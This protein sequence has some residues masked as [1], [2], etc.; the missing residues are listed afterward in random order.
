VGVERP[1]VAWLG[2]VDGEVGLVGGKAASLD[3][4]A[5]LGFRI[6][7]GFCLTTRA[8][9]AQL[10]A[11]PAAAAALAELPDGGARD[12]LTSLFEVTPLQPA[13]QGA[14]DAAVERLSAE[15]AEIGI[16]TPTFAVRS[17]GIGEDG[18]A[19]SYAGLHETE[20]GVAPDGV[21]G[22]VRRCWA[23]MWSAPAIAYRVRRGLALDGG[24]MAVVVQ[25]LVPADA[26]AVV[27]TRHP[28]TGRSD[29]I[30]V[31]GVRGLGDA[32]VSGTVTPDTWVLDHASGATLEY[33]PGDRVD[34]W[35]GPAID[36]GLLGDL[37]RL[38]V[39]VEEGFGAPVDI[40]AAAAA[41]TWY[42]LQA[43]PITTS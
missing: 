36:D 11:I 17:S 33:A 34:G 10:A 21:G 29:Q 13:V 32:M 3:R 2:A 6:P 35:T 5:R 42:L 30:V 7:P 38:A 14:L 28:V 9:E 24:G 22:A 18:S 37:T 40:E 8:F 16:T 27:F 23:S 31:T 20:L 26:A 19:A 12:R 25:A 1:V 39:S 4:L 43:R 41:G 15:L